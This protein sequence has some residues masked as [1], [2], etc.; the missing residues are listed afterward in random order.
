MDVTKN[1][2][3]C[4]AENLQEA[5][6]CESCGAKFD[7]DP[8]VKDENVSNGSDETAGVD[9]GDVGAREVAEHV[10]YAA[11][12]GPTKKT[13]IIPT[14]ILLVVALAG[15]GVFAYFHFLQ[16]TEVNLT[17]DL[18][19]EIL[20][21]DGYNGY[22][23]IYEIDMDMAM[24]KWD[25]DNQKENVQMFLETVELTSDK[26]NGGG[27]SN[28]DS[29]KI[30][31]KYKRADAKKYKIQV[32]GEEKTVRVEG[33]QEDPADYYSDDDYYDDETD[34]ADEEI[35][36]CA[37]SRDDLDSD[38]A[39]DIVKTAVCDQELEN[40]ECPLPPDLSLE[41]IQLLI[42]YIYANNGLVFKDDELQAYFENTDW[43]DKENSTK[44][45]AEAESRFSDIE[46]ANVKYLAKVRKEN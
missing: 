46:R 23:Y 45:M 36:N 24:E 8:E 28:G 33:L 31:A 1:C 12:P 38:S 26:I 6:F 5:L 13:R 35:H 32:V 29:I 39:S 15:A 43:Y 22:G 4:G 7:A 3:E 20:K 16:K 44:D 30:I 34:D 41:E 17:K 9:Y 42:N 18:D 14:I 37:F 11:E 27:L 21:L 10:Q 2:P 40:Q 19:L 25:I